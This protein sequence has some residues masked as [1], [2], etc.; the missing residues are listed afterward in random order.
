[1][2]PDFGHAASQITETRRSRLTINT[3]LE[4]GLAQGQGAV[5]RGRGAVGRRGGPIR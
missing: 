3:A 1:M 2:R 5:D 4:L